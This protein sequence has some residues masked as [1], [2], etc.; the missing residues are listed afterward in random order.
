MNIDNFLQVIRV[1]YPFLSS[2]LVRHLELR[3][4]A[5]ERSVAVFVMDHKNA[6]DV[7]DFWNLRALGWH[8]LPIPLKLAGL[9]DI[10]RY[11]GT[12]VERY[13]AAGKTLQGLMD[14]VILKG[15]SISSA[16]L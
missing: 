10:Q 6:L 5:S 4:P 3:G 8:V 15:R 16:R 7:I 9:A 2:L 12:F 14:P 11:A 1:Q 13:R